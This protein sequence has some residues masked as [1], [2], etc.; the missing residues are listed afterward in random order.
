MP[1][2]AALIAASSTER[3][4]SATLGA[5]FPA[6]ALVL[7]ATTMSARARGKGGLGGLG[8]C[9][10]DDDAR[11]SSSLVHTPDEGEPN[12]LKQVARGKFEVEM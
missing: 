11:G 5:P 7:E 1:L 12:R 6:A 10:D 4:S 3:P 2:R 8:F 9:P